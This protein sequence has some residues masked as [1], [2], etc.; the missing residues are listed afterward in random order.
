MHPLVISMNMPQQ[1]AFFLHWPTIDNESVTMIYTDISVSYNVFGL[2]E[3]FMSKQAPARDRIL[4]VAKRLFYRDG[5]RATGIDKIIAESGVAKMSLYRNFSSKNDL[6]TA[7]L[8][9]RHEYWMTWFANSVEARF[10]RSRGLDVI[11]DALGEWFIDEDFRGCAFINSVA[12]TGVT[13]RPEYLNLAVQHKADLEKYVVEL[14]VRLGLDDPDMVAEEVM[15]CLEGM[16]VRAQF[17]YTP[18][19][20]DAGRRLLAR[21]ERN[22]RP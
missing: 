18:E 20:V 14:A 1:A 12:E 13:E 5:L 8:E 2:L 7:F 16:I 4:D 15:L 21:I 22:A 19:I 17:N 10:E 3:N 9:W 11:A 6:I